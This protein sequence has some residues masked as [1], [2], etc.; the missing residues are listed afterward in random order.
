MTKNSQGIL[1]LCPS[2]TPFGLALGPTNPEMIAIAQ[3]SLDFRCVGISP[4]LRLL[5]SAFLLLYT[6]R[7]LTPFASLRIEHFPTECNFLKI[8]YRLHHNFSYA[9]TLREILKIHTQNFDNLL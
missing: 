1:T 9:V 6:P 4:T 5:I 3:E 7:W 2:T 8:F